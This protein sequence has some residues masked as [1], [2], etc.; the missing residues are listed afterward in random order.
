MGVGKVPLARTSAQD[1]DVQVPS[2]ICDTR[3]ARPSGRQEP[4]RATGV[5]GVGATGTGM[6][7]KEE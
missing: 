2:V 5:I 1:R 4:P 6:S 7:K 3:A